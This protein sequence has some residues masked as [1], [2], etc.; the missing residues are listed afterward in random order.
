MKVNEMTEDS[1]VRARKRAERAVEDMD[2]G[3][4]KVAAFEAIL[5]KLL[6]DPDLRGQT[7]QDTARA[8]T[9]KEAQPGTLSGRILAIGSEGFFKTQRSLGEIRE[10]LGSRGWHYPLSTMSGTMQGLVRQR[11]LRRERVDE[12]KKIVWKYSNP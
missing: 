10:A 9:G 2:E 11:R 4:L 6:N 3:P 8:R 12:G 5:T 1:L 7:L